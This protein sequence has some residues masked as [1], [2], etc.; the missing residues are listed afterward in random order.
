[1]QAISVKAL[2]NSDVSHFSTRSENLS[3]NEDYWQFQTRKK[4]KSFKPIFDNSFIKGSSDHLLYVKALVKVEG[5]VVQI[6]HQKQTFYRV[7]F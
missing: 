4:G 1:M 2:L 5:N 3:A 7:K 6:R